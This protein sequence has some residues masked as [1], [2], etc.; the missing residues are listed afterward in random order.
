[1]SVTKLT[2]IRP[3]APFALVP[4][5]DYDN[6]VLAMIPTNKPVIV[7]I[8]QPRNP[9][10]FNLF[11]ALASKVADFHPAFLD[12]DDAVRWA[13]RRLGMFKSFHEKDG[14]I[15]C[16]Y[17]SLAVESMDQIEFNAFFDKCLALWAKEIGCDPKLLLQ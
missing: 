1:M 13:K 11:W 4:R 7:S 12:A 8:H 16:E 6:E 15:W 9:E 17:Q 3:L 10:H 2:M 14:T 5:Y